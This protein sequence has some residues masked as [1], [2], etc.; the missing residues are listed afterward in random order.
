MNEENKDALNN[1]IQ[2]IQDKMGSSVNGS[3]DSNNNVS[4]S[5]TPI[6]VD[7]EP[8]LIIKSLNIGVAFYQRIQAKAMELNFVSGESPREGNTTGTFV[9]GRIA[10]VGALQK[11]VM[12]L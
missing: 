8:G 6:L 7:V 9:P 11:S 3:D 4:S 10:A 12:V 1:L 2:S 5:N